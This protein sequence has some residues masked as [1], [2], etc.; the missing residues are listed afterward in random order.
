MLRVSGSVEDRWFYQDS[1]II[2]WRLERAVGLSKDPITCT[3][4]GE[5]GREL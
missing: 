3:I 5:D 1:K 2:F 4:V